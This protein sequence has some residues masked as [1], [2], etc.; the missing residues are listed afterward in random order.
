MQLLHI[1]TSLTMMFIRFGCIKYI[2][3]QNIKEYY[4]L[5]ILSVVQ[6]K[7]VT[8]VMTGTPVGESK[9]Q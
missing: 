1:I 3:V 4:M 9:Q 6:R 2:A 7:R 8:V 5:G